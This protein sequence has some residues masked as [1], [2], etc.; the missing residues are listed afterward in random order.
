[1]PIGRIVPRAAV[2]IGFVLRGRVREE[3]IT[4]QAPL[5]LRDLG[6]EIEPLTFVLGQQFCCHTV[7]AIAQFVERHAQVRGEFHSRVKPG[8]FPRFPRPCAAGGLPISLSACEIVVPREAQA[9]L[10]FS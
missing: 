10:K 7:R 2:L 8:I 9:R 3:K 1:M 4:A 6:D 5:L